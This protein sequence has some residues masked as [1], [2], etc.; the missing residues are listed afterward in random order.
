M[1]VPAL[2]EGLQVH[3]TPTE[4][5]YQDIPYRTATE[6][7]ETC[8]VW[9]EDMGWCSACR[10]R[11]IPIVHMGIPERN[12]G[13]CGDCVGRLSATLLAGTDTKEQEPK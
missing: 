13:L 7:V 9:R 3:A 8:K 4:K 1:T 6:L 11:N 2:G 5:E 10:V 12:F